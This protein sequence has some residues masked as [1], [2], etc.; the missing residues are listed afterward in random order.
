MPDP[1]TRP[2]KSGHPLPGKPGRGLWSDNLHASEWTQST[3]ICAEK[4]RAVGTWQ[5][6]MDDAAPDPLRRLLGVAKRCRP[7][8]TRTNELRPKRTMRTLRATGA[9][10]SGHQF[11]LVAVFLIVRKVLV[12]VVDLGPHIRGEAVQP[13]HQR[14][15]FG[16]GIVVGFAQVRGTVQFPQLSTETL[17]SLPSNHRVDLREFEFRFRSFAYPSL[18]F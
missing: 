7:A 4:H 3:G 11:L 12:K 16:K 5:R 14:V 2:D 8:S 1:L 10:L 6:G 15:D 18:L 13:G 17:D 9:K